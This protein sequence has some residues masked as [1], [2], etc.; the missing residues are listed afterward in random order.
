MSSYWDMAQE[1]AEEARLL[2]ASGKPRGAVSRA[3]YAMF[4]AARAALTSVDPELVKAKTHRTIISRFS[5]LVV[6]A[7]GLDPDLGRHMNSAEDS[8]IAA[9]YEQEAFDI[10]EAKTVVDRM[11]RFVRAVGVFLGKSQP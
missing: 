5:Q 1:A 11:E 8:R 9:D 2:L 7:H 3:Y 4:D 6:Q 10:E